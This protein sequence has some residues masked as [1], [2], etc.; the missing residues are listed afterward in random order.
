[1]KKTK[2][3]ILVPILI[4]LVTVIAAVLVWMQRG[5]GA[6]IKADQDHP[7]TVAIGGKNYSSAITAFTVTSSDFDYS[8]LAQF[9]SLQSVDVTALETD[10]DEYM[11]ICSQLGEHIQVIWSVPFNG[12]RL[13]S[14][15][16]ELHISSEPGE[17]DSSQ[18]SYFTHLTDVSI[19]G[20]DSFNQLYPIMKV[21]RETNPDVRFQC[22][23]SLYGVPIDYETETLILNNIPIKNTDE[24]GKAIEVFPNLKTVEMC[25]C[26]LSND[27]MGQLRETYPSVNFVWIIHF[28]DFFVRTDIQVFST[29]ADDLNRPGSSKTFSPLFRYC[30]ELRALDLGHMKIRDI[31]EIRNLKKLHTLILADNYITDISPLADLK[32]LNYIEIFQNNITDISPL[33]ELPHLQDLNICYNPHLSNITSITGCKTLQRLYCSHCGMSEKDVATIQ[34]GLPENCEFN[35]TADECVREGWRYTYSD[36]K[37]HYNAKNHSIREAFGNWPKIKEYPTWDNIIYQ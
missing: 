37:M 3:I 12:T 15:T 19:T 35:W 14:N 24:L 7:T 36:G 34:Q 26:G 27:E 2:I 22:G 30:T 28:L 1:M 16:T 4:G 9:H 6:K 25:G 20:I 13:P 21:I 32:E 33:L 23:T 31:S 8:Q 18:L 17:T 5:S 11:R 29:L 10:A